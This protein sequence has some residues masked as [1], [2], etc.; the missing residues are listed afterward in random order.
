MSKGKRIS[1]CACKHR[2]I[3]RIL[4]PAAIAAAAAAIHVAIVLAVG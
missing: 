3:S 1:V 2:N 4:N